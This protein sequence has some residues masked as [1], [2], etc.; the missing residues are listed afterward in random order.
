LPFYNYSYAYLILI[1]PRL[2]ESFYLNHIVK[3]KLERII[4]NKKGTQIMFC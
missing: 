1:R 2:S 4:L 3:R